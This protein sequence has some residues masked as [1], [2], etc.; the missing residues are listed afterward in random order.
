MKDFVEL[1]RKSPLNCS[2]CFYTAQNSFS[3]RVAILF[4]GLLQLV[5]IVA[6][7]SL[8]QYFKILFEVLLPIV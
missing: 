2:L 5:P 1:L 3:R 6:V 4:V 8:L 7:T